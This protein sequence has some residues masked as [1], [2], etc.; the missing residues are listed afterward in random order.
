MTG[1]SVSALLFLDDVDHPPRS[2]LTLGAR[3]WLETKHFHLMLPP[4]IEASASAAEAAQL[5]TKKQSIFLSF[6]D[7]TGLRKT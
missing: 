5:L 2:P 1:G 6:N 3:E 7:G 4:S